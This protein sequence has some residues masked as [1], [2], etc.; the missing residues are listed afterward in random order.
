VPEGFDL[1]LKALKHLLAEGVS[2]HPSVM[3]AFSSAESFKRLCSSLEFID[4]SLVENLEIEEIIL[5][6]HVRRRLK[7]KV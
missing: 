3:A 1:Q 2:F 5:Y 6:P 7:N 4:K